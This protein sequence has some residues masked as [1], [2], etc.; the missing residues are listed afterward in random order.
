MLLPLANEHDQP[1]IS[2]LSATMPFDAGSSAGATSYELDV[3]L[4]MP[5]A[6]DSQSDRLTSDFISLDDDSRYRS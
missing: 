4:T 5:V 3:D 6:H 1:S 2:T